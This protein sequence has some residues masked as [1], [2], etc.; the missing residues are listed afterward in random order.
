MSRTGQTTQGQIPRKGE[1]RS[2]SLC[3]DEEMPIQPL[4]EV[5]SEQMQECEIILREGLTTF[6]QVGW[7]LLT[8]RENKLYRSAYPTFEGYC[9]ERWGIGRSYAWRVIGAAERLRLLP[10]DAGIPRPTNEFQIRPFL[11]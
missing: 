10:T 3:A 8:I 2:S 9:R 4:T 11:K 6:F 1:A 5:E 7:A